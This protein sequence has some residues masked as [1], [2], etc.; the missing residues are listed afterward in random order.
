VNPRVLITTSWDDGHPLDLRVADLLRKYGLRA[1]FYIPLDNE[2]PVL[3]RQQ[4]RELSADFEVGGHTVH[5][6]DLLTISD[7]AARLEIVDCKNELEQI[8]GRACTTFCFPKGHFRH[9][10][11]TIAREAGY[12][13]VRTVELMSLKAPQ[14]RDGIAILPTTI[15][16]IPATLS[17]VA[18]NSLKRLRPVNFFRYFLLR[19][20]DWV[21]TAEAVLDHAVKRGGVFHLW[22][23]SWEIDRLDQWENL[24]RFLSILSRWQGSASFLDNSGLLDA[25]SP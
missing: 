5:H 4:I 6:S 25:T 17:Q 8:C 7:A 19:K 1:T 15:Q 9:E 14:R 16:A 21:A 3:A 12:R 11:V 18:R 24:E 10:H 23:H 2:L 22:G 13:S 20:S